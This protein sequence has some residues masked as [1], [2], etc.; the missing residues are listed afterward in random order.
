MFVRYRIY[1]R[2]DDAFIAGGR[3]YGAG[4]LIDFATEL[5]EADIDGLYDITGYPIVD[6][7][8]RIAALDAFEFTVVE[9]PS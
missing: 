2:L 3:T 1:D 7:W 4:E 9:V 8:W 5:A 6:A